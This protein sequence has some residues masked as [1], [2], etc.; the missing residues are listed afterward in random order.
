M[1]LLSLV[2][3]PDCNPKCIVQISV[4]FVGGAVKVFPRF[5][6]KLPYAPYGVLTQMETASTPVIPPLEA[7]AELPSS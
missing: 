7:A 5:L 2:C 3:M 4:H 1:S 6:A